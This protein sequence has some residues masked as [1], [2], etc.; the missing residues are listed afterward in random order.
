MNVK[1][2]QNDVQ[3]AQKIAD[4]RGEGLADFVRRSIRREC[5]RYGFLNKQET[6]AL[7]MEVN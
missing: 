4:M 7:E 2:E 6:K 5:A 3:L 1:I